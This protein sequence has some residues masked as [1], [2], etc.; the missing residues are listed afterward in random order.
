M[1]NKIVRFILNLGPRT[2][3]GQEELD[4]VGF[5]SVKDRVQQLKLSLVF[6]NFHG[7]SPDYLKSNFTRTSATQYLGLVHTI[8]VFQWFK[9]KLVPL[10]FSLQSTTG[11]LCQIISNKSMKFPIS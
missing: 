11:I 7:T 8:F 9:V 6:K 10:S 3:I 2:H 1:Q 4:R 5:L